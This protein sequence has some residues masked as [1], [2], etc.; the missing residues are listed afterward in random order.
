MAGREPLSCG[1]RASATSRPAPDVLTS[2]NGGRFAHSQ[3]R[4]PRRGGHPRDGQPRRGRPITY[5]HTGFGSGTLDGV[6]FGGLAPVAFTITATGDTDNVQVCGATCLFNE[7]STADIA[8]DGLGTYTITSTTRYFIDSIG[9]GISNQ[10][11]DVLFRGP[12]P[13]GWNMKTSIGPVAGTASLFQWNLEDVETSGGVLVF[14]DAFEVAST[15][16]AV[17]EGSAVPEPATLWLMGA[18]LCGLAARRRSTSR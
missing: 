9:V 1:P 15:F 5:I 3:A 12:D 11:F 7:N 10:S 6:Q 14:N 4:V 17:V 16:E 18:A 8:I 13:A 2:T